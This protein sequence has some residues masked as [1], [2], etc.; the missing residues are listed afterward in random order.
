L[1][2][3]DAIM[4]RLSVREILHPGSVAVFGA[5]ESRD[6]FGGRIIYFLTRHGFAGRIVPINPRRGEIRGH[7][8]YASLTEVPHP[9]EVAILAVSTEH[10]LPAISECAAAGVGCCVVITTGFAEADEAG[11]ALQQRVLDIAQPVGM[12]IV[13]PNCMGLLNPHHALALCSSVVLDVDRLL[14]GRLGLISQSGALMVSLFDRAYAE[15]IGFSSCVSLGN[16]ADLEICDFLEYLV[17]DPGT[18]AIALYV[19]GFRDAARFASLAARSF[20]KG[21]PLVVLK[22]GKTSDG[23]RAAQSHTASLAGSYEAFAAT[24]AANGVVLVEDPV[25]LIRVADMLARGP[26]PLG[27]GIAV[28]SGSG[29]GAGVM[30][31]RIGSMGLQLARLSDDTRSS[32]RQM[33]LPPQADNPVDLGGRLP[34]QAGDIAARALT[35]LAADPNVSVLLLYLTSMPFFE[36]QTRTLAEAAI[37]AGKPAVAFMLPGPAGERPRQVLRELG[38]PCF[39]SAEDLLLTLRGVLSHRRLAT[40]VEPPPARPVDIPLSLP[41]FT[42]D[43]TGLE[44]LVG[45]YG[46]RF[47]AVQTCSDLAAA[48]VQAAAIGFPVVLKG[49]VSGV[50]HKTDM[51]LVKTGIADAQALAGAWQDIEAACAAHGVI[52]RFT[53]CVVQQQV[54]PG[55]ELIAAIRHD[56]QFGPQ[57][58]AGAGGILV[59]L[60]K[61][62]A[63]ATAPLSLTAA[64]RLL[65]SLRSAALFGSV[66]GA[67]P[68]DIDAAADALVRLSWLAADLGPSL[69]DLEINPLIVGPVGDGVFAV[70]LRATFN[71]GEVA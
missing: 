16:Q 68:R 71:N 52:D 45:A 50:T 57:V 69:V 18:D 43:A 61:D 14:T 32:L 23:V 13:G 65:D 63:V 29:G 22:T 44:Q 11:A 53:G 46:V 58:L 51:G 25:T 64:R 12:R 59:E 9:V 10:L 56:P 19:E 15:N 24:C 62:V 20:A 70:D 42:P 39:D 1:S 28:L 7:R 41:A 47:P 60:L 26:A 30:V 38:L 35:T 5:S 37:A 40:E 54:P 6:K 27:D 48:T 49:N 33:L 4:P 3:V 34:G 55:L 2:D 8:A 17:D 66:R 67:A 36:E 31:D 21:K